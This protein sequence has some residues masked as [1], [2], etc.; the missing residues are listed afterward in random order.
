MSSDSAQVTQQGNQEVWILTGN[1]RIQQGDSVTTSHDAVLWIDY[2]QPFRLA[3][4]KMKVYLEGDVS[5]EYGNR[6]HGGRFRGPTWLGE[7][8]TSHGITLPQPDPEAHSA[9]TPAVYQRGLAIQR[10]GGDMTKIGQPQPIMQIQYQEPGVA[11]LPANV[12]PTPRAKRITINNRYATGFQTR[13]QE[14]DPVTGESILMFDSG[15]NVL[16]DGLDEVGSVSILADR[17]VVWSKKGIRGIAQ[18]GQ[19]E[20]AIDTELYLEGNIVFRQ[21]EQVVYADRMYY[22]AGLES[23]VVLGAELLTPAPGYQGLVRLKADVLQRVDNSH[24]QAYGASIT[25]SRLGVP[26]YWLQ[27]NEIEFVDEQRQVINPITG[28][29][30]F[31]PLTAAP[32]IDHEKRATARNN[33]VYMGGFPVFYWPTLSANAENPTFY[34]NSVKVRNDN[35]FGTQILTEWDNYEIFGIKD[36]WEGTEW[37]TS[38]DYLSER[39]F[40]VGTRFD[41]NGTYFPY[42]KTPAT[43]YLDAWG[44]HDSG[45]DNLG[46]DR[47]VV[48]LETDWRGKAIGRHRQTF[49]GDFR[50]FGELGYVSDRNFLESYFNREWNTEKDATTG[51]RLEKLYENQSFTLSGASRVN[52][53]FMQTEKIPQL[54]HTIIGESLLFDRLSWNAHSSIG[55]L[56]LQPAEAPT[57]PVDLAK[58]SLFPYETDSEG[59]RAFTTQ[60]LELPL[61]VGPTKITPYVLGQVGYWHE[62][63]NNND[64][65][66]G[67]GQLG[68]RGSLMMWS[69]NRAVQSQLWNLN[70]LAHKVTLYGDAYYADSSQDIE[71]FPLYDNLDDDAQEQFAR[72]F[73][74][75][76]FNLPT[77][78]P[79]PVEVDERY[80]AIRYGLQNSVSSPSAEIADDLQVARL[81]LRQVWQ[82][83]RGAPGGERII[84]W[85]KFDVGASVFPDAS[86]DNFGETIGLINYD[87]NWEIGDRFSIVSDGDWDLFD[88][89]LQMVNVGAQ[90]S[91]PQIGS[92]Y[93]GYTMMK[94][95]VVA[96]ILNASFQYRMTDKWIAGLG[97]SYDFE[98][99]GNL[100]QNIFLTRVGESSLFTFNLN[101]DP[102]RAVTGIGIS[103]EPR[104]FATGRFSKIAGEPIPPVGAFGLE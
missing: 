36:P 103:F 64:V 75:N 96:N 39:G 93:V 87:F 3:P 71:R 77:N 83:K 16:I 5:V 30:Q 27:S 56:H 50:F 82:T 104:F 79:L 52:D 63:I 21:G 29:P 98:S 12:V 35:N 38:L 102:S 76:T 81:E 19:S 90:M 78:V 74:V 67:Y 60:S 62:D 100:G 7:L 2:S 91:R 46:A 18:S 54:D 26:N 28:E 86:R 9:V 48:P 65:M 53:F 88:N 94:S 40:G 101:V 59:I 22:N 44:I 69:A 20:E 95:P 8:A 85:I 45:T 84:D 6:L 25:T 15:V 31:D 70:G 13:G 34:L 37:N 23:G 80:Y 24:Y 14:T 1:C 61:D 58:F 42:M 10:E 49:R 72:R 57:N 11:A 41:F 55:Y 43:G 17:V 97:S 92:L 4:H 66:R 51:F 32:I 89:G 33:F 68:V 47:R 99:A 73:K